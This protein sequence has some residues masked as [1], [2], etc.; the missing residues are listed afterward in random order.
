MNRHET[1]KRKLIVSFDNLSEELKDLFKETY[2]SE[3]GGYKP[4][5]Q[6]TI[7]P[8]GEPI[9]SVPLE[10]DDAI[11][12]V[13]FE[14]RIDTHLVEEDLDKDLFSDKGDEESD[15]EIIERDESGESDGS[16]KE[17]TLK[18]GN[19]EESFNGTNIPNIEDELA[20][21]FN[22]DDEEDDDEN[23]DLPPE[24]DDFL[25]V[26]PDDEDLLGIEKDL[27]EGEFLTEKSKKK[28][29]KA[30][31]PKKSKEPKTKTAKDS[32]SAKIEKT[33]KAAKDSTVKAVKKTPP[34][35]VKEP[36]TKVQKE[37]S[38]KV[39]PAKEPKAKIPNEPAA[40]V[41]T[42]KEPKTAKTRSKKK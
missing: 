5:L 31:E 16:H 39:K 8:S 20:E 28:T 21:E 17:F 41:K 24:D 30:K 3:D 18:H 11:Y 7:K 23:D 25:D 27:L 36:K 19:Y 15:L 32:K 40:K 2:P 12:M 6:K 34:K 35:T 14:V 4:Y 9:F 22:T 10:T 33:T 38:T 29:A 42:A 26:E 13:K 1:R 37:P